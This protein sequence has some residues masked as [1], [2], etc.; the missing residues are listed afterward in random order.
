MTT[1]LDTNVLSELTRAEPSAAVVG[2]VRSVESAWVSAVTVHELSYGLLMMPNG[3]RRA[4][5]EETVRQMLAAY[6]SRILPIGA[7]EAEQAAYLR[8]SAQAAGRTMHLADALIGA[9]AL[10]NGLELATRNI[11]DFEDAPIRLVNPWSVAV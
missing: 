4:S 10:A 3:R 8:A 11:A 5:L 2:F 1:L 6:A 7:P 9:T